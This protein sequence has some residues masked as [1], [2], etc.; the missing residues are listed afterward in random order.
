MRAGA[1]KTPRVQP[2]GRVHSRRRIAVAIIVIT[3]SSADGKSSVPDETLR[4]AVKAAR[5]Y[6]ITDESVTSGVGV[7]TVN[8]LRFAAAFKRRTDVVHRYPSCTIQ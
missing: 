1:F 8:V 5:A 3:M 6:N 2:A 4:S 7:F